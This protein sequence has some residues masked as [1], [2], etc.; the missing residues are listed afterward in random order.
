[1][2]DISIVIVNYNVQFFL[3]QCLNSIYK[4]AGNLCIEVIVVDNASS[5]NSNAMLKEFFPN[6]LLIANDKNLGFSAANNQA[7]NHIRG[8]YTLILNPDT[9]LS[10]DTLNV[11]FNY[12][13]ANSKVG[14]LGVKMLDG[15]GNFHKESKRGYPSIW[16]SICKMT[17]LYKFFPKSKVFNGYYQ[18]HISED[19]LAEVE[20]LCGA[21]MF[22]PSDLFKNLGGFDEAFFMYGEDIDLSYRITESNRSIVYYPNSS[23]IHYK[24]ESRRR[25]DS[26]YVRSFYGAMH[27][28]LRKHSSGF[29]EKLFLPFFS[30]LIVLKAGLTFLSSIIRNLIKPII[31]FVL[32]CFAQVFLKNLWERFYYKD[33]EYYDERNVLIV[34]IGF[35]LILVFFQYLFGKYDEKYKLRNIFL[36]FIISVSIVFLCYAMLPTNFRF[37]RILVGAG[38]FVS[39]LIFTLTLSIQNYWNKGKLGL[40][41]FS[42]KAAILVG[43]KKSS[44]SY[45]ALSK[46]NALDSAL[47]GYV[48]DADNESL[49]GVSNLDK[50]LREIPVDELVFAAKDVDYKF[51]QEQMAKL[52]SKYDY[53]ILSEDSMSLLSSN[54]ANKKGSIYT[55]Q[56]G[57]KID[58]AVN[59]RIKRGLDVFMG[60]LLICLSPILLIISKLEFSH[61]PKLVSAI[62]GTKTII[63]YNENAI[64][65]QNFP[66]I[67]D[68]V[69]S[70]VGTYLNE[71]QEDL[72]CIS[73]A[74]N[75]S[76]YSE[77]EQIIKALF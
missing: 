17:G 55:I 56:T 75:H 10:E 62:L 16:S 49:G 65:L 42:H 37:S 53:K 4:S 54:F 34:I 69:F 15:A 6:V 27:I 68:G 76:L 63:S 36:G 8:K 24:G 58:D 38:S 59:K 64:Q 73:F 18:G 41:V 70:L 9:L 30:V 67:K 29:F 57:F 39:L 33:L 50:L 3:R 66:R 5:D 28:F 13:E 77:I 20:I 60:F 23:I 44:E 14:A 26:R 19:D 47:I 45:T 46:G 71:E 12:L 7:L 74:K 32:I 11:C 40:Q 43:S 1:M 2:V 52:G 35:S 22:M 51:M 61:L 72:Y 25:V 48:D 21:F 31:D